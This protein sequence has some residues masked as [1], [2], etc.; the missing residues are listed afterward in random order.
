MFT[1]FQSSVFFILS[2][3]ESGA[4]LHELAIHQKLRLYNVYLRYRKVLMLP[5]R[6]EGH[7]GHWAPLL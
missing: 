3:V 6:G 2:K 4:T 7:L 1:S 5:Q